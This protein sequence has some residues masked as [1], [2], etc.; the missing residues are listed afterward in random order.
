MD[1]EEEARRRQRR[2]KRIVQSRS[3]TFGRA[4]VR[5]FVQTDGVTQ[6]SLLAIEL[7]TTVIPLVLIGTAIGSKFSASVNLG[8]RFVTALGLTGQRADDMRDLFSTAAEM[9]AAVSVFG[10]FSFLV[11][12]IPMAITV[13]A[14]YARAWHRPP[15][16]LWGK[17]WRGTAW[18]ALALV[19]QTA[20]SSLM[21]VGPL[22]GR[23]VAT[24]V[25]DVAVLWVFWTIT[26]VV[27]VRDGA[28]GWRALFLGGV[29]GAVIDGLMGAVVARLVLPIL[30]S[31]WIGFGP[32]GVAMTLMT[33]CG[34][35][36]FNWVS[37][38]CVSAILWERAVPLDLAFD[39]NTRYIPEPDPDW[40]S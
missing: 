10:L 18:F 32:I 24:I 3:I 28:R 26:P 38:A 31:G 23:D 15:F 14:M 9:R 35:L 40:A 22:T 12:G 30:L 21:V 16:P 5:R 27:L 6:S 34:V 20:R 13:A 37:I 11:W 7:F 8:D 25:V 33:W 36:A 29:L 19:G 4:I 17:L 39:T 1:P 2:A